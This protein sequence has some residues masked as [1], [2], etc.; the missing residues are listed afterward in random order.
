MPIRKSDLFPND[1]IISR[2]MKEPEID[3]DVQSLEGKV[4]E[5]GAQSFFSE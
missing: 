3:E 5:H 4:W 1:H 2:N